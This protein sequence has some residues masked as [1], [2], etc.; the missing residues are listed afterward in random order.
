M[1]GTADAN[2]S[3]L[4]LCCIRHLTAAGASSEQLCAFLNEACPWPGEQ[5][6]VAELSA[7]DIEAMDR[8]GSLRL[9][10]DRSNHITVTRRGIEIAVGRDSIP[11]PSFLAWHLLHYGNVRIE[12]AEDRPRQ[13]FLNIGVDDALANLY[14]DGFFAPVIWATV[15]SVNWRQA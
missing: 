6:D 10:L 12:D 1:S 7:A 4:L 14:G 15:R 5:P 8:D 13:L 11:P 2:Y 9:Y 3:P